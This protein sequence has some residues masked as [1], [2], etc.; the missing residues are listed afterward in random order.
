L[1]AKQGLKKEIT[2]EGQPFTSKDGWKILIRYLCPIAIFVIFSLYFA[3]SQLFLRTM[4]D[5]DQ[6]LSLAKTQNRQQNLFKQCAALKWSCDF[7]RAT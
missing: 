1:G 5:R 7:W 2:I 6:A 4:M 3:D